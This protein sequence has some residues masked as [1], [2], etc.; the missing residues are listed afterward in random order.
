[1]PRARDARRTRGYDRD[2]SKTR[3][4]EWVRESERKRERRETESERERGNLR[5]VVS[6]E[7]TLRIMIRDTDSE[8]L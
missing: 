1:M 5:E 6:R 2:K 3:K 8:S 7:P 4:R